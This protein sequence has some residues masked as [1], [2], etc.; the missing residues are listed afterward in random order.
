MALDQRD[1]KSPLGRA[2]GAQQ[3]Q[4]EGEQLEKKVEYKFYTGIVNDVISDPYT[5]MRQKVDFDENV[6][7]GD[8]LSNSANSNLSET[9]PITKQIKNHNKVLTAPMNSITAQIIDDNNAIDGGLSILCYPFFPPHMSLPLNP[10]E[11][12]WIIENDIKGVKDYYWMCRKVGPINVDDI[13]YTNM[14]RLNQTESIVTNFNSPTNQK[15]K[16]P[17]DDALEAGVSLDGAQRGNSR[18]LS[19]QIFANSYAYRKEFTGE[20]V[21]RLSK[22]C[23]D[24]LLQGSN[25]TGIHLTTEKFSPRSD[26]GMLNSDYSASS[27]PGDSLPTRK[28]D[29]SAID[30]FVK[31]KKADLDQL[32]ESSGPERLE[33]INT[34]KN[35]SSNDFYTYVENDKLADMRYK[36]ASVYD[37]ELNDNPTDATD[38]GARIY[39]S[40]K[41]AV[42]RSFGTNFSTLSDAEKVG[43]SIVTYAQHN[44]VVGDQDVRLASRIG[45]AYIDLDDKGNIILKA[46]KGGAYISL[47]NDGSIAI[48]PGPSGLLYLGGEPSEAINVPLGNI[49]TG[50]AAVG[51]AMG[52]PIVTTMGG[53]AGQGEPTG[54]FATKVMFK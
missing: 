20:P 15:A 34:V 25:N 38:V 41:C 39:L 33:K 42:D 30:M 27:I 23:G 8:L 37:R 51:T 7:V 40:H 29:S 10:G 50:M 13:N 45:E 4:Q 19:S 36:D 1:G 11:Y 54:K 22:N 17:P 6:T 28:P 21:P 49:G 14:E 24:L 3:F 9:V 12:V 31:R 5:Y 35:N 16:V 52:I 43:P 26:N 32:I 18:Y 44:R 2:I 53:V 48:V 46:A 47:R